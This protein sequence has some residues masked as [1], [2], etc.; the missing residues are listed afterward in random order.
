MRRFLLAAVMCGAASGA[1]AADMPDLPILR[2]SFTD[3]LT[4]RGSTGRASTSAARAAT[5]RSTQMAAEQHRGATATNVHPDACNVDDNW[6]LAGQGVSTQASGFGAFAGYNW[7]W[8]D[9]VVGLEA[10]YMHG[11][12]GGSFDC[13]QELVS[14]TALS[15]NVLHDVRIDSSAVDRDCRTWHASASAPAMPWGCFL[16][17]VFG[18]AR[19][20]QADISH[21]HR[22]RRG[23]PTFRA[24][25]IAGDVDATSQMHNHLVY[26]YTA[27]PR[28]RRN[29]V[30]GLFMRAEWEYRP[31]HVGPSIPASTPCARVSATSSDRA[32]SRR[33]RAPILLTELI[34][35]CWS[36]VSRR[37]AAI[38]ENLRR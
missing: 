28:R 11:K 18:G 17:Y 37:E 16:P 35:A 29:A 26:G 14:G 23:H 27:R 3:G 22:S 30:G 33:R 25:H 36:V 4:R 12:F 19:A 38:D 15:D 6:K 24:V 21:R 9:V 13:E 7:Q 8:D 1:H 32:G 10:N 20:G 31:L 34:C 2:G 5:A